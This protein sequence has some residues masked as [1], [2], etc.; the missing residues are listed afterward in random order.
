MS[1]KHPDTFFAALRRGILG[2]A[3]DQG[4]VDGVNALL[5]ACEGWPLAWTAYALA[6]AYHETAGT[7][8]PIKEYGS[9]SYF[10]RRYDKTGQ[11]PRL[12]AQL[13]NTEV[14]DGARFAGR[15][16]VQLTGRANYRKAG[17]KVG[18]D[19]IADPDAA[20][21][22]D[23]AA[24]ILR[25]GMAEGWFTGKSLA[26]LP[27]TGTASTLAYVNARRIINGIDKAQKIAGEA[28]QFEAALVA[29]GWA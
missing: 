17:A 24:K 10:M 7:M 25:H 21:R 8:Q 4:E 23:I 2:P 22:P 11:K 5:A 29:G 19:L 20:M 13:G 18:V 16:Y 12:A 6:T 26:M 27:R 15:G 9:T 1:L 28:K 14:G 3:L